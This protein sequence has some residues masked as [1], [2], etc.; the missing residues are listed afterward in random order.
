MVAAED[1]RHPPLV[2]RSPD[3]FGDPLAGGEDLP[4]VA[5]P[6]VADRRSLGDRGQHVPQ[7]DAV[8]SQPTDPRLQ[9]GVADRRGPHVHAPP[10][11]TEI[12]G[13]A[14]DGDRWKRLSCF[15]VGQTNGE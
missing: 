8:A 11:G 2:P 15:H 1:E 6:R 13:R 10:A 12:E 9:P 3:P 4:Q 5:R 14:D 7:I